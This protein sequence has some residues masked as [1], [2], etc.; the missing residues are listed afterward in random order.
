MAFPGAKAQ[1]LQIIIGSNEAVFSAYSQIAL[2]V[3]TNDI[4]HGWRQGRLN[5]DFGWIQKI[6][7]GITEVGQQ[8][9]SLNRHSTLSVLEVLPRPCDFQWSDLILWHVNRGIRNWCFQHPESD[10]IFFENTSRFFRG[11]DGVIKTSLFNPADL[12]HPSFD[13]LPPI[14]KEEYPEQHELAGHRDTGVRILESI[15]VQSCY[16]R[17]LPHWLGF[18]PIEAPAAMQ[19]FLNDLLTIQPDHN[20]RYI[21]EGYGWKGYSGKIRAEDVGI[22]VE[23]VQGINDAG[24]NFFQ[25]SLWI[26][27]CEFS[28]AEQAYQY[29]KALWAKR[30]SMAALIYHTDDPHALKD[31]TKTIPRVRLTEWREKYQL[32]FITLIVEKKWTQSEK[33]RQRLQSTEDRIIIHSTGAA[34]YWGTTQPWPRTRVSGQNIFGSLLMLIR[35]YPCRRQFQRSRSVPP[36]TRR[37]EEERMEH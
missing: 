10:R 3:G 2:L 30:I 31:I 19:K 21:E 28:S 6:V 14:D 7:Q 35:D 4:G 34:G 11:K 12:L 16:A 29:G 24:S 23:E 27:G 13:L 9:L 17:C 26:F 22:T 8:L 25:E 36:P 33:F 20:L 18:S 32:P 1:D 37:Q 15:L 5:T